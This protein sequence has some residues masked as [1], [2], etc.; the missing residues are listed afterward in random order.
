MCCPNHGV[1]KYALPWKDAPSGPVGQNLY[2][3]D[4][5]VN[6]NGLVSLRFP[7][8]PMSDKEA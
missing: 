3:I 8:C 5:K 7:S 2:S 6:Y 1:T 4:T